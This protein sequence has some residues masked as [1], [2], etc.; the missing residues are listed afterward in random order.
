LAS[1]TLRYDVLTT[2]DTRGLK[3]TA[4]DATLAGRAA[5][6]LSDKLATQSKTAQVS[7]GAT[8]AL[9]KSD[10]ILRDAHLELAV[11]EGELTRAEA[12]QGREAEKAAIKTRAAGEA[13]KGA[14]SNFGA[15]A[16]PMGA[17][18]AAGVALAPVAVTVAAGLGGLGLAALSAS[19]DTKAMAGILGPL[20]GDL[21]A[22]D[23]SLKPT[24][25]KIFGD[26]AGIAGQALHD[27]Q[28]VAKA[29]GDAL[30]GVLGQVAAEFKSGEWQQFFGF[31]ARTAGP[32]IQL[33]GTLFVNLAAD[34]P[35][36]LETLQPVAAGLLKITGAVA[37]LPA[38]LDQVKA[39]TGANQPGFF[40]GTGL[41]RIREFITW[42]EKHI[43]AGNKSISDLIGLTGRAASGGAG[44]ATSIK[45]VAAAAALAAP[46]VGTLA[47]D[48]A[49]LG[50]TTSNSTLALQAYSDLWNL[51]VGNTVG[52]QQ[53]VLAVTA[54][55]DAFNS[56]VKQGGRTSTAAQQ[57]FLGIFTTIGS[58]LETLH[59]NGASVDQLNSFYQTSIGR[60]NA[61]HGLTPAQRADVQGLTKD[62][63]AW[64]SSVT[65]LSGNV[66]NAAH[67]IRDDFLVTMSAT[68]RLVPAAKQDAD[69][70]AASVLKAGTNSRATKHDR[71]VLVADLVRSGLSA[72]DAAALVKGFQDKINALKGKT[73]NVDL[74]TS[75]HGTIII[76]GTGINQRTI[77]TTTG[78]LRGPG[79]H[80]ANGWLVSGGVPGVDSVPIVAMPGELVVPTRMVRAGAVDHLRG[81]IPGFASGGVVGR[82]SAAESGAGLAEA[83][84]GQLA[85][86]AFAVS[87]I[88]AAKKAAAAAAAASGFG[89]GSTALGGDAAANK[90]LARQM[91]PWPASQWPSF[92][93]LEMREAGYNRF[94]RNPSSGAYGIPQ[95]LPESK[96]P[97][98]GQSGGGSHAGPQLSWMYGYIHDRYVTPFNAALHERFNNWY[99][100]GGWLQ[101]GLTMAWNGTGRPEQVIP[102]GGSGGPMEIRLYLDHGFADA[103]LSP[104]MIRNI[105]A[106]VRHLGGRGNPDSVQVAFGNN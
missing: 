40:G 105:K 39:K 93:Y 18:I 68:H 95:A 46:K 37:G 103:G 94:A 19:K 31:M 10:K 76:T 6:E 38:V 100:R 12:E 79:G 53:A 7:A 17:A 104:Q 58:G 42:G 62:Y 65:G 16:S 67:S 51:F 25:L 2:A 106:T 60:L 4:R 85:A 26:G 70:F 28:P 90:A 87:A 56:A 8:L 23:A 13:A 82:V 75:G 14:G 66:V 77:N 5:K 71:D 9:A 74:T 72:M 101:P 32:D 24:V 97:F 89:P 59:K 63:L 61:L 22:F 57:A 64:A 99:D 34:V 36:V 84:W 80:T 21:A 3:D 81:K 88:Q 27:L 45:S 43:P 35:L 92:D 33:L 55:F 78:T 49:I 41:D 48:I 30:H 69:N 29:T 15:L 47:G 91:F 102:P 73:V 1:E 96:L 11:A 52:D 83:Q 50:T 20:K 44:A 86:Q 54:A 98:A